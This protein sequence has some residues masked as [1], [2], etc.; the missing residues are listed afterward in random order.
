VS[1]STGTLSADTNIA[2]FKFWSFTSGL[3]AGFSRIQSDEDGG[4]VIF[5][6]NAFVQV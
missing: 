2:K 6:F 4:L 5:L 1:F 3:H